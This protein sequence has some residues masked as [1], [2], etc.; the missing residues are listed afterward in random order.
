MFDGTFGGGG[1]SAAL[2]RRHPNLKVLGTD[3][4]ESLLEHC[5]LEYADLVKA[6]RL[7]LKHCNFVNIPAI[8]LKKE[9]NRKITVKSH[10]DVG[11]LDLGFS[12]FQV[13]DA[14]RGFSYLPQSDEAYLDMRFDNSH[15]SM[16]VTAS[17]IVNGSS[18]LE[19]TQIFKR[20]GDEKFAPKLAQGI[21]AARQGTIISTT[22]EL[23]DAIRATFP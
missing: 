14:D 13:S 2:L 9:F 20:F 23:K 8:D 21:M 12:N 4:D 22:G 1:H 3:L 11:L 6:R 5:R 15:D 16:S 10:F 7:A 17:D 18:E 19:L